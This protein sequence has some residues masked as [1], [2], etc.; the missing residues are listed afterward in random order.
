LLGKIIK[1][2]AADELIRVEINDSI[3]YQTFDALGLPES[4]TEVLAEIVER[5]DDIG[6]ELAQNAL[7][8]AISLSLG[9]NFMAEFNKPDWETFRRL[10]AAFYKEEPR[11]EWRSN[12]F[13][14][15]T[16]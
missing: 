9:I 12:I 8:T 13:G 11:R 1:Q 15:V 14:E 16:S 6:L 7:H 2:C 10:V 5:F 4:F 3:C